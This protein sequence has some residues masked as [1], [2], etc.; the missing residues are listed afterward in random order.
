M[1]T[2]PAASTCFAMASCRLD[3]VVSWQPTLPTRGLGHTSKT[4]CGKTARK[5]HCL[6]HHLPLAKFNLELH[7]LLIAQDFDG[8]LVARSMVAD[9]LRQ[10]F[11]IGDCF[12]VKLLNN[13]HRLNTGCRRGAA[14]RYSAHNRW[15]VLVQLIGADAKQRALAVID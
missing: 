2:V 5:A 11:K 3:A 13:V 8:H 10:A 6:V 7:R 12:T 15:R 9:F 4:S 14:G 1:P